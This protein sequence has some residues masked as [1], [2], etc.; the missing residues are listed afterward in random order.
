MNINDPVY[1]TIKFQ[2]NA[3]DCRVCLQLPAL[4][5]LSCLV[6]VLAVRAE[7][8]GTQQHLY[9]CTCSAVTTLHATIGRQL[10]GVDTRSPL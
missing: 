8:V 1:P 3:V 5:L 10:C 4:E 9:L 7:T 2:K 6:R